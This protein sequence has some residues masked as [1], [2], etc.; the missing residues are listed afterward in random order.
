[1]VRTHCGR[2]ARTHVIPATLLMI[3]AASPFAITADAQ[4]GEILSATSE[5][6]GRTDLVL[7]DVYRLAA[8]NP[9]V[10]AATA[11]AQATQARVASAR[12]PSDPEIQLGFMNR[13]LPSL[14][15]MDPLGMTQL[16]LMQMIPVPGKLRLAGRVASANAAAAQARV[17]DV[18]WDVR[19]RAAMTFYDL[20]ASDAQLDIARQTKRLVQEIAKVSQVMYSVGNGKQADVLRAQVEVARMTEDITRMESMRASM[21]GRLSAILGL[22]EGAVLATPALPDFPEALP[23]LNELTAEALRSRPMIAAG[24]R[25]LSA[26]EAGQRLARKEIWTDLQVGVQYGWREGPMGTERMGSLMLGATVPLYARS[27]QLRMRDEADA[28]RAMSAADLAAMRAETRGRMAELYAEFARAKNLRTLYRT[29]IL[30]QA[31]G[32]VTASF[33]AYRVG[34]VNLMTLLDNQMTVN[35]YRQQVIELEAEQGKAI[36]E[37]EMLL[38]RELFDAA[39]ATAH[40]TRTER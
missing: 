22:Q 9:R 6:R 11:L 34:D 33:A 32:T 2:K 31:E 39:R 21:A 23:P 40:N 25:D 16:Q 12:R 27:R 8:A 18:R 10:A 28:M 19:A 4:T 17:D 35:R 37:I 1:M 7:A 3:V 38:G 26:A 5:S 36:A 15:P 13:S 14:A 20:Y 30:P 29:T 24:E